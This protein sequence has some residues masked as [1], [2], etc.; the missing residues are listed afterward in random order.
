MLQTPDLAYAI[1]LPPEQA[2]AYFE[3]LDYRISRNAIHAY[4]AAQAR[5]F[6]VTGIT[7]MD[8]LQDVKHGLDRALRDGTTFGTF[9]NETNDLLRRRG[10]MRVAGGDQADPASGEIIANLPPHRMQT[11]FR[12]NM[13]SALMAGKYQQLMEDVEFAP[14]WQYVA[15]M[16]KRTRPSHAALHGRIFRY[17]DPI[18]NV[19]FPPCGFNCR[20]GVRALRL[21]DIERRGLEVQTSEGRLEEIEINVGKQTRRAMAYIDP[22]SH[23]RFIAD[24]GFGRRPVRAQQ[25]LAQVLGQKLTDTAPE[26]GAQVMHGTPRLVASLAEDY[27]PWAN[28]ILAAAQAQN[29]YRVVAVMTP[30]IVTA[31]Q[32]RQ[33]T[34]D[35]AAIRL[36][37]TE[38]LHLVR[39]AGLTHAQVLSLPGLINGARAVLWDKQDHTLIYVLGAGAQSGEQSIVRVSANSIQTADTMQTETLKNARYELIKGGLE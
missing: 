35:S 13:Q 30:E 34:P 23:T 11:I 18:W 39:D 14:Y 19:A 16:D 25:T 3:S 2:I 37:D 17:D 8:V 5:A 26:I 38:L 32:R 6:T 24:P 21:R 4:N 9:Q 33:L 36:R 12:T 7:R 28:S 20:C 15:V 31:L 27:T 22:I 10:W 1:G 29:T